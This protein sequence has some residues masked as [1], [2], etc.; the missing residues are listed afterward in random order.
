MA[1]VYLA[2]SVGPAGFEKLVALKRIHDHLSDQPDFVDMFL[3][4]ARIASQINHPNICTVFDFGHTD[5]VYFIAMEYLLGEHTSRLLR[6]AASREGLLESARWIDNAVYVV[7]QACDGLHAAHELRDASGEP[8][9]VVHRDIS[10]H[11]LFVGYDGS[12]KVVDFGIARATN[13]LHTTQAGTIKGRYAYMAPEQARGMPIDRRADL[14]SLGVVLWE[15]L[16]GRRLFKRDHEAETI[17]ALISDPVA[18]PSELNPA[19][20]KALDDVVLKALDR[21]TE[22]RFVTA[23]E[24]SK[25]LRRF[26][27]SQPEP[28]GGPELAELMEELFGADREERIRFIDEARTM[29]VGTI[30][31][32]EEHTDRVALP[33]IDASPPSIAE[34]PS[35]VTAGLAP[36]RTRRWLGIIGGMIGGILLTALAMSLADDEAPPPPALETSADHARSTASGPRESGAS[37][38]EGSGPRESPAGDEPGGVAAA[39]PAAAADVPRDA[40]AAGSTIAAA[41]GVAAETEGSEEAA[42][43]PPVAANEASEA[44]AGEE[45]TGRHRSAARRRRRARVPGYV[46]V[47][48][49]GGWADIYAG[50]RRVGRSPGRVRLPAGRRRLELRP[51][52]KTPAR[53][54]VVRVRPGATSRVAVRLE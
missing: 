6:R 13:R 3:D 11:N 40:A 10:P 38:G 42:D 26:L 18:R 15:L 44:S 34:G 41:T 36:A 29:P 28:V 12:V 48:T 21:E 52:G 7:A 5:G 53:S 1:K 14:W 39:E 4:E 35:S 24:M 25:A 27:A 16:T 33:P 22:G 2:R 49:P 31:E 19:V 50:G 37:S 8:L 20:P 54:V 9:E 30:R 17:M 45:E 32:I 47:V 23:R 51:F 43:V 46:N